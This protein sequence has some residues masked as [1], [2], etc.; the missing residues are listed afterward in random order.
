M[1]EQKPE[2]NGQK[3]PRK[4]RGLYTPQAKQARVIA[5]SLAGKSKSEIARTEHLKLDTVARILS[6]PDVER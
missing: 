6:R 2:E 1:K 3:G 5:A 4:R